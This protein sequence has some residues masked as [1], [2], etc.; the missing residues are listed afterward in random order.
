[1]YEDKLWEER[2]WF[3]VVCKDMNMKEGLLTVGKTYTVMGMV[4]KMYL[5]KDDKGNMSAYY[6]DRFQSPAQAA[7]EEE[8]K[9]ERTYG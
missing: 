6:M 2:R 8:S 1:M 3:N 7:A 5:I 9:S 4:Q